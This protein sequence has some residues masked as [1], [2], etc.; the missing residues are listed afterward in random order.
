NSL[1]IE[2]PQDF[3]RAVSF[4][5]LYFV[6]NARSLTDD[7]KLVGRARDRR[8][9]ATGSP[10]GGP[11]RQRCG[12]LEPADRVTSDAEF[13]LH[14]TSSYQLEPVWGRERTPGSPVEVPTEFNRQQD[15]KSSRPSLKKAPPEIPDPCD[16]RP[17]PEHRELSDWLAGG[18]RVQ[19]EGNGNQRKRDR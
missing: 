2:R 10:F 5:Y 19:D 13:E 16:C 18:D 3:Q 15:S 8:K 9:R 4:L 12:S 17:N 6:G 7:G 1:K 14:R 11:R